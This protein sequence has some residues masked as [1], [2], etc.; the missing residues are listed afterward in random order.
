MWLKVITLKHF[1]Q[2]KSDLGYAPIIRKTSSCALFD[3][4]SALVLSVVADSVV[5]I[6]QWGREQTVVCAKSATFEL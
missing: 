2:E 5:A 3:N 6:H 1:V 4:I